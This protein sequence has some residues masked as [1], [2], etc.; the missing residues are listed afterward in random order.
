MPSTTRRYPAKATWVRL[1]VGLAWL[2]V[3]SCRP[4]AP[5]SDDDGD[6]RP[7]PDVSQSCEPTVPSDSV[8]ATDSRIRVATFN[9]RRLFDHRCDSG[10]CGRDGYETAPP[11]SRVRDRI[12]EIADALRPIDAD[13]I[14]FQEIEKAS[15]LERVGRGLSDSEHNYRTVVFGESGWAGSLDV[16]LLADA[17]HLE[18]RRYR[19]DRQLTRPDG[20][21]TQFTREFLGAIL[22]YDDERL[23]LFTAHFR[24]KVDDDPGQRLA[25]ARGA[26]EIVRDTLDEAPNRLAV[27]AGDLNTTPDD[28]ALEAML[29]DSPLHRAG[30][31]G[32]ASGWSYCFEGERQAIDHILYAGECGGSYVSGSIRRWGGNRCPGDSGLDGSD[33]AAVSADFILR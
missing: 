17:E 28:P 21:T 32:D 9:V 4:S 14:V 3:F 31:E 13:I 2:F 29:D 20:S 16:G 23:A 24:S 10:E 33:H 7:L 25:E 11:E 27:L 12:D 19:D 8:D 1:A 6:A 18:T 26:S 5:P 22:E 30:S 15:L